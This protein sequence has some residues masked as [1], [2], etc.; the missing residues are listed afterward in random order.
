MKSGDLFL[1]YLIMYAIGRFFLEFIRLDFVPIMGINLNQGLMLVVALAAG[2]ALF[3]RH[4][5]DR[6]TA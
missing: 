1:I 6:K 2:V 3:I 5:T 4:R